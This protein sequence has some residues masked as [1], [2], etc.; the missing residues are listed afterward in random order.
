MDGRQGKEE[1]SHNLQLLIADGVIERHKGLR[2]KNES[3]RT[4]KSRFTS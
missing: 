4:R 2:D 1:R 3:V